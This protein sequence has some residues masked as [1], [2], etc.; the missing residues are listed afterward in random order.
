[1]TGRT[2]SL[3]ARDVHMAALLPRSACAWLLLVLVSCLATQGT[4]AAQEYSSE[5]TGRRTDG[6]TVAGDRSP[7]GQLSR[8]QARRSQPAVNDD[9]E[10]DSQT[11]DPPPGVDLSDDEV[12]YPGTVSDAHVLA[13][14]W[15]SNF[16]F[17]GFAAFA[18]IDSGDAGT[19]P[20]GGFLVKETSLFLDAAVW[21]D[22]SFFVELQTNRL[23]KDDQ[24][25]V[26]TG[27]VH[28]HLRNVLGPE[29]EHQLG[30]K[31][32]RVDI[33]FGEEYLRQ[34]ASDNPLISTTAAYPYGWD[35]GVVL[36]GA[37]GGIGWIA[38]VT[39]GTDARS[40]EDDAAKA[41][42]LKLYGDPISGLYVS[43]S[44]MRNGN[45]AK[46]AIEFGGSH[47]EPVG[48]SHR[49]FAGTSPSATVNATLYQLDAK[50]AVTDRVTTSAFVGWA[51]VDDTDDAFD[52]DLA[53][54][55]IEPSV[56]VSANAWA[57]LRYSEIG[58]YDPERGYHFDGKTTAGGNDAFGYD[59]RRFRRL[60]AG[61][62]WR[63]NPRVIIKGELGYDWFTLVDGAPDDIAGRNRLLTGAELVLVF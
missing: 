35:E 1:M 59:T 5:P 62:G 24:T 60:S 6:T 57:L 10:V 34:D 14:P 8:F 63:P 51:T 2:A 12:P 56:S 49:S 54:F 50:Y 38:A 48:A 45:A 46:S 52:R 9:A 25:F 17:R 29:S 11:A 22:V 42:N 32:G 7:E 18:Y 3:P 37:V 53:W 23:G 43:G 19:R 39:D 31:V 15:W 41:V 47:F 26:R 28:A 36:Y 13:R 4:V 44:F 55:A 33:P 30:L 61:A 16:R 27:E 40:I 58:T 20:H 21:E